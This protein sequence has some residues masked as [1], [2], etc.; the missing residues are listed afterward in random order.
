MDWKG[1]KAHMTL[2]DLTKRKRKK[3]KRKK[4]SANK[5]KEISVTCLADVTKKDVCIHT[6]KSF[7]RDV[8]QTRTGENQEGG[9]HDHETQKDNRQSGKEKN[10]PKTVKQTRRPTSLPT[11]FTSLSLIS[12]L[13]CFVTGALRNYMFHSR[14][15]LPTFTLNP[16]ATTKENRRREKTSVS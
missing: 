8:Q 1:D 16:S 15:S 14:L 13:R 6:P 11:I 2:L 12:T 3:R 5:R 4:T 10:R 7:V 9:S